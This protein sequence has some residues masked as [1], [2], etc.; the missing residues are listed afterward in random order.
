MS[1]CFKSSVSLFSVFLFMILKT[2]TSDPTYLYHICPN[3]TTYSRNSS[4]LTNLRTVLSS[5]SSPNAAY[6]SLFDNA[7]AGEENDSNRVY[8]VFLCRGDVSAEICRDCVAFAANE[9]LQ[10]CPREKVAVIWYDECMVRYSNQS[11]VGQ[12]RIRPGVFLTNKQNITENQVSRFNESLPALLIDVAVK[13]ALSSRKFATEKANFTVF[14]T[15][16][17]LVQCTPDLTNQDCESCLRQVINYL[18]RCCDRSVGGRVIAPSCSFRYELYPFYNETIA[19]AP[20]APPPSST[21]AAP[22]LNIPSEKGKGK[23]LTVIVTAIA[24]PVSV[25]VL[26]LGAMC[27]LLARRRNNKL[28]AET[29]DLDEDGITSTETLQFQFS[30]IEAA[31]NK[32]S[33]S[34][35]L[36]HGGFGEVY[37]GQLITGET[38]AIKRLSQGSTQGAEEFKN[39]VDVVAKLQHRNLAKLLGYCLDGEEKILVYEFVPNKS[40]D[41]FLFDNEK[42]RV[43]DWQRRYKI[44]E[45]IARG[46]LYLHRDSRLTI[47]HRD[48]KAS[49]I[50]LDADMHPKISDFGMARIFGVDQT[51]AN[52]KRIVG[53]YGYMSPEYAI[54]G[55]YSVKSDVYSFGVLVL[56]LITGKKN[57]SFYEEDGLGDLVT[58]VWKLWVENSPLELVDEAMRGNFQTNEVIRCI[59][60]ALLCVQEDSSERPSMDDIL[61]MMNSFTV[62]LPIPKRS[63]FL[64]RTMKD[65][66]DPRSGGSASDHSATSK[67]L[68]L[69]V[70]DSSITIVYPR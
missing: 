59:H 16:Y 68:P 70:D 35:K 45:G 7:A 20:M 6:A 21:V 62:T 25:C 28:S 19:A 38:V 61:V 57:S 4:Y 37:K 15:I 2:V 14:Q 50:L 42:R 11:I 1:S 67:S 8:G 52:T 65:S 36:G 9:T 32:F 18:P 53:T 58:Y 17:S 48:L 46:I 34:N 64:L 26:L 47:I 10:R 23:N 43:L 24:V 5:L 33:E 49:N 30:A 13:A 63:G 40:L 51:Q 3:T 56:E 69:S 22:P 41:Y 39:E 44:I 29:E 55:K 27:W 31:T 60:I 12:M 54:H 66:R